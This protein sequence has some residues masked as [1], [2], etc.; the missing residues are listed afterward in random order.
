MKK[1]MITIMILILTLCAGTATSFAGKRTCLKKYCDREAVEGGC[2]C[3]FHTCAE[4]GCYAGVSSANEKCEKH[5]THYDYSSSKAGKKICLKKGCD[6][7]AVNGGLYC[8]FHTCAEPGC[9]TGVSSA[10][11]RCEK[12]KI[13]YKSRSNT[14]KTTNKSAPI[15]KTCA[16]PNCNRPVQYGS[17]YCLNHK[18]ASKKTSTNKT[19]N[20]KDLDDLDIE[21]L[22]E[23]N[24]DDFE[25]V[26]D[27]WDYL[28]DNPDE[29]DDY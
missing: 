23:D 6:I 14:S 7:E 4:P 24:P 26:E 17:D 29:W 21:G 18:P 8:R 27:A 12:H 13:Q 20:K 5:K 3:R 19:H 28:E 15:T 16:K 2:Y 9:Y 11:E 10:N 22:Y 25:S 1:V